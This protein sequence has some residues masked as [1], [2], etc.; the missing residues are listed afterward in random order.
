M[1][2]SLLDNLNNVKNEDELI[3]YLN[4]NVDIIFPVYKDG[5]QDESNIVDITFLKDKDLVL[6]S[7]IINNICHKIIYLNIKYEDFQLNDET[8]IKIRQFLFIYLYIYPV[9]LFKYSDFR[10]ALLRLYKIDE[11]FCDDKGI[12]IE[13]INEKVFTDN[14]FDIEKIRKT[15]VDKQNL[16]Y[17]LI[18][19]I[20]NININYF[21]LRYS[22]F[23][24]D[25]ATNTFLDKAQKNIDIKKPDIETV[26]NPVKKKTVYS[27]SDIHG[28]IHA[29]IIAL[30][31]CAKIIKSTNENFQICEKDIYM[32]YMLN[33]DLNTSFNTYDASLGYKWTAS[34]T[35]LVICG[36]MLDNNRDSSKNDKENQIYPQIEI[37]LIMFIN[38]LN[39][40]TINKNKESGIFKIIGNHE[41][42]NI[43]SMKSKNRV[44][45]NEYISKQD[46]EIADNYYITKKNGKNY[47]RLIVFWEEPK[48]RNYLFRYNL[49][50]ALLINDTIYVHGNISPVYKINSKDINLVELYKEFNNDMNNKYGL[51]HKYKLESV[52]M[53]VWQ[54]LYDMTNIDYDNEKTMDDMNDKE[55]YIGYTLWSRYFVPNEI[56]KR[57]N[58]DECNIKKRFPVGYNRLIVGHCPQNFSNTTNNLNYYTITEKET[59]DDVSI[60]FKYNRETAT[61]LLKTGNQIFNTQDIGKIAGITAECP[62]NDNKDFIVYHI[63]VCSSRGFDDTDDNPN[64]NSLPRNKDDLVTLYSRTP[65][66]LKIATNNTV[67]IIKSTSLNTRIHQPRN[68][69]ED[70]LQ[71]ADLSNY[72]TPSEE[73]KNVKSQP[74]PNQPKS[75]LNPELKTKS[76]E[77]LTLIKQFVPSDQSLTH[78]HQY[79]IDQH[80]KLNTKIET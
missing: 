16:F 26:V 11:T 4:K 33:I 67:S 5:N 29:F 20:E 49:Y 62:T 78:Y 57:I 3:T 35:Y 15:F 2:Q 77:L 53:D 42:F 63:D 70:A 55:M 8:I 44:L 66:I 41:V 69:W 14:Y 25:Y 43:L 64:V 75:A 51:L 71:N 46:K 31:D 59:E 1:D 38:E 32:E 45:I 9:E 6:W 28:D 79:L 27:L 52:L 21:T 65:Q 37:K 61:K 58:I 73:C 34:D 80:T 23:R 68:R 7:K 47:N 48:I 50:I 10:D 24:Y 74:K 22:N 36:D 54:K 39:R 13:R 18:D 76:N 40:Q 17:N 60:T 19:F 12:P 72:I 56:S 30:R